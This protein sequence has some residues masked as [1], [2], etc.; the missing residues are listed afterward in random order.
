MV[1]VLPVLSVVVA[2]S[3]GQSSGYPW[4]GWL[5]WPALIGVIVVAVWATKRAKENKD[6]SLGGPAARAAGLNYLGGHSAHSA[7]VQKATVAA[8]EKVL[9]V[10]NF[11]SVLFQL[12]M[13]K[14]VGLKVE[15]DEEARQRFTV[16]R[17]A[18]TGVF[19]L[20]FP[21]KTPGSVL[22]TIDTEDGPLLFER[23]GKNKSQVLQE[24]AGV[25]S[26]VTQFGRGAAQAAPPPVPSSQEPSRQAADDHDVLGALERLD[27]L[28][29]RGVLSEQ[30]FEV[31]KARILG[32]KS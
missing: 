27:S 14:V 7:L 6:R 19:A 5:F 1:A 16:T 13:S 23:P 12:P 9:A 29:Q 8:T 11:S 28:R 25:R 2:Q 3:D 17:M 24:T 26:K 32:P 4:Y 30:E 15:T 18:L 10:E 31:Q 22:V 21:K 20:A